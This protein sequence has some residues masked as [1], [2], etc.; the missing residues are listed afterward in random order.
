MA[1]SDEVGFMVSQINSKGLVRIKP[2]GGIWEKTLL[3]KRV[4][5]LKMMGHSNV[6]ISVIAPHLLSPEARS[7]SASIVITC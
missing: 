3:A 6:A 4:N 7:K 5:L 1:H 2:L